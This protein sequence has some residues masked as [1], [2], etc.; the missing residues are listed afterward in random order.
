ME[1]LAKI[2]KTINQLFE[3]ADSGVSKE[4]F[5]KSIK[6][7]LLELEK[8]GEFHEEYEELKLI[9]NAMNRRG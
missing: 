7:L 9:F 1:N 6:D 8:S 2:N 3:H 5:E 4:T